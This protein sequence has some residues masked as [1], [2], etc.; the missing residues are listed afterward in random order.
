MKA[1]IQRLLS[2]K[3]PFPKSELGILSP[4][5]LIY[6]LRAKKIFKANGIEHW[7]AALPE[8][9]RHCSCIM[10]LEFKL[11]D[12]DRIQQ[13]LEEHDIMKTTLHRYSEIPGLVEE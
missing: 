13:L 7:R 9:F 2:Q 8:E 11:E 10:G 5:G 1:T 12:F 3:S 6:M 4:G